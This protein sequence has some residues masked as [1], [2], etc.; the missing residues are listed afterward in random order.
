VVL[1]IAFAFALMFTEQIHKAN[2]EVS[3]VVSTLDYGVPARVGHATLTFRR[4]DFRTPISPNTRAVANQ[5]GEYKA[6]LVSGY[7]YTVEAAAEGFCSVH[8]PVFRAN[9]DSRIT[10]DFTL[11]TH[12]H[13]DVVVS[14]PDDPDAIFSSPIPWYFE[15]NIQVGACVDQVWIIAFGKRNRENHVIKYASFALPEHPDISIPVT[16]SIGT[17]TVRSDSAT[18][19]QDSRTLRTAGHVSIAD[20]SSSPPQQLSCAVVPLDFVHPQVL[21]CQP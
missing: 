2:V 7:D 16:I 15:E 17:Y 13:G 6:L 10:F 12:C 5:V 18:L 8:R 9:P 21:P 11:T 20:G 4:L 14:N 19:D 1:Q 3:G